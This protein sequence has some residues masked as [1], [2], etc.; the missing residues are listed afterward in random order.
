MISHTVRPIEEIIAA[1]RQSTPRMHEVVIQRPDSDFSGL[2]RDFSAHLRNGGGGEAQAK[3]NIAVYL[4]QQPHRLDEVQRIVGDRMVGFQGAGEHALALTVQDDKGGM[5]VMR[6]TRAKEAPMPAHGDVL[7]PHAVLDSGDI[8]IR[9]LPPAVAL[10]EFVEEGVLNHYEAEKLNDWHRADMFRDGLHNQ[11]PHL[12]NTGVTADGRILAMDPGAV[13]TLEGERARI[14]ALPEG[15]PKEAS[16]QNMR[17]LEAAAKKAERLN[18]PAQ[19]G[20]VYGPPDSTAHVAE[21]HGHV[22]PRQRERG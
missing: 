4:A 12:G 2:V 7:R 22:D 16:L 8:S 17:Q 20:A 5:Q 6:I 18:P 19:E 9:W 1:V 13:G 3:N 21:Y 11:D 14:E 15:S 10:S